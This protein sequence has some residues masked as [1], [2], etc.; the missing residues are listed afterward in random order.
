MLQFVYPRRPP[1][2]DR[3]WETLA[4][5]ATIRDA[6]QAFEA[7]RLDRAEA[8]TREILA[9]SPDFLPAHV[10]L[11]EALHQ[12]GRHAEAER[13]AAAAMAKFPGDPLLLLLRG[14]A[15]A[16]LGR[17][18]EALDSLRAALDQR[19]IDPRAHQALSRLL[20]RRADPT[21]R[22]SVSVITATL[23][24]K[25][26]AQAIDS[27]QAQSYPLVE[28]LV[29][30]DGPACREAVKACLPR[31][32]RHAVRLLVLPS[33]TSRGGF[34]GHRIYAAGPYL[35][36]GDFVAFLDD[37]HWFEPDHLATLM[38]RITTEGLAWAYAL[39][40]IVDA[41]GRFVANDDCESLGQ[42]PTWAPP[43]AHLVDA[44]C[45]LLRRDVAIVHGHLWYRRRG[46]G[47]KPDYVL[48]EHLLKHEPDCGTSGQ[49]TVNCRLET[50]PPP[51][52]K[53]ALGNRGVNW[54]E[55]AQRA[56]SERR[57]DEVEETCRRVLA[58]SPDETP[59][60]VL[61]SE[62]LLQRGRAVEAE[63]VTAAGLAKA[64]GDPDLLA[65]RGE[66]LAALGHA[67]EAIDSLSASVERQLINPRAHHALSRLRAQRADARPRL[68]VTILTATIG[69]PFLARAI[70]GVQAQTYPLVEHV[71]VVDGPAHRETVRACLPP[72]PRH[73]VRLLELPQNTGAGGY[74][75]HR[76]Y[77]AAPFLV[78]GDF[79]AFLD[80]DNW[81]DPT[82]VESLLAKI[83]AQ[84]LSWAYALRKIIDPQGQFLTYDDCE[85]LG[86]WPTWRNPDGHLVDVNCY[87]LRRDLAIL[88][89][90]LW[91]RRYRV[92]R[93][94]DYALCGH[95]LKVAPQCA[96]NGQYTVNYRVGMTTTS[97]QA[98][99][100]EQG[101]AVMQKRLGGAM[102]WRA[103]GAVP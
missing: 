14:E 51:R 63:Q 89:S 69:T 48:R 53:N 9:A 20:A 57:Y 76:I 26:L 40:K 5:M 95:L 10:G 34:G 78:D 37:N 3:T 17:S 96:S 72:A 61:L 25:H 29:V 16:A 30:A 86:Q 43:D 80:E 65:I 68:S 87:L 39:R 102:P 4:P 83:T 93:S 7:G 75:A 101:N 62:S 28:H 21:P 11:C 15:L 81:F 84:G 98:R 38:S 33:N 35:V 42:G 90:H 2:L 27:V 64:G 99:Y 52:R 1:A 73:R 77:G 23:G 59:A 85:S 32:S 56:M 71:I 49:Y 97:V 24:G 88:T 8:I 12:S 45:Y 91:Y 41:E 19:L 70:E 13:A 103:P 79:V 66:A 6:K 74:N 67:D 36:N 92:Q 44:N 18:D 60:Q 46:V 22:F 82:H 55:P 47:L 100:F 31:S 94:P 58:E 54:M 50:A